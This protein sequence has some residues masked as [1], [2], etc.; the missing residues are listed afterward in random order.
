MI[1]I[2]YSIIPFKHEQLNHLCE[3]K[4][5]PMNND[6]VKNFEEIKMIKKQKLKLSIFYRYK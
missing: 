1:S 4:I 3:N 5:R 2:H 6:N